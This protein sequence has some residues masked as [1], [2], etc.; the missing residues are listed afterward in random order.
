MWV[1]YAFPDALNNK[2]MHTHTSV[3]LYRIY[4]QDDFLFIVSGSTRVLGL[5][6]QPQVGHQLPILQRLKDL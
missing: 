6:F 1:S 5:S 3:I 4:C 2:Y